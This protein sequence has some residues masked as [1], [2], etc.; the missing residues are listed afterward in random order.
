MPATSPEGSLRVKE[1]Q[2]ELAVA[3]QEQRV[4]GF[5]DCNLLGKE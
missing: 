5:L 4:A 3:P 1:F 2:G